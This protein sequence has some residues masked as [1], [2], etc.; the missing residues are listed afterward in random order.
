MTVVTLYE[1]EQAAAAAYANHAIARQTA[2]RRSPGHGQSAS[3]DQFDRRGITGVF[4]EM[5][6]AKWCGIYYDGGVTPETPWGPD[7]LGVEVRATVH[8]RGRSVAYESD[9]H[10]T[11]VLCVTV[12]H[13]RPFRVTGPLRCTFVGW[14]RVEDMREV[15]GAFIDP[16]REPERARRMGLVPGDSQPQWWVPQEALWPFADLAPYL[17]SRAR[18]YIEARVP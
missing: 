7:L 5:A 6:L 11:P 13:S 15:P 1:G 14:L 17:R 3:A 10:D 8:E 16:Q 4:G 18:H 9:D 2:L 12:P